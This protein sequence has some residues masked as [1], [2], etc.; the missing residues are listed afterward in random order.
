[1]KKLILLI[2]LFSCSILGF[3]QKTEI[4]YLE[5]GF[6]EIDFT[7]PKFNA[8]PDPI[9]KQNEV[10]KFTHFM[11]VYCQESENGEGLNLYQY[12][13]STNGVVG[14]DGKYAMQLTGQDSE[15]KMDFWS[16]LPN[17][18]Q[19]F[20]TNDKENGKIVMEMTAGNGMKTT[21]MAR[22]DA[23]N[24]ADIFWKT[25]KKIKTITETYQIEKFVTINLDVYEFVGEEGKMQILLKD[26][27]LAQGQYAPLKEIYAAVGMGG[28]GFLLNPLNNHVYLVFQVMN[29]STKTGCRIV[30][31]RPESKTFSGASYKPVGEMMLPKI[32]E[33][34]QEEQTNLQEA[35]AEKLEGEED[36][37]LRRLLTDQAKIQAAITKKATDNISNAAMLNDMAEI[38][39]SA[40]EM[41]MNP[42]YIYQTM[43]IELQIQNR[44]LQLDLSRE[45]LSNEERNEINRNISCNKQ[46]QQ[47]WTNYRTEAKKLKEKIKNLEQYEQM[48]KFGLLMSDYIQKASV[49]CQ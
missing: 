37:E 49:I 3:S 5:K 19:R 46:Q 32:E 14:I 16:I 27:G 8:K 13:N 7:L 25:A 18:T 28:V 21:T 42:D 41:S 44:R 35:L 36:A 48:E 31:M 20:Y 24:N 6:K 11:G 23:W 10:Y 33:G 17:S 22:F 26:L 40:N 9:P 2:Y 38:T 4:I 34:F 12:L 45:G 1:M 47:H 15:A 39:R 30:G 29:V 43:N